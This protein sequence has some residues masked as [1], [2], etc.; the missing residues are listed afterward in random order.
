MSFPK[1]DKSKLRSAIFLDDDIRCR[2]L[3][4]FILFF[5]TT[6]LPPDMKQIQ[7]DNI[8]LQYPYII[9]IIFLHFIAWYFTA[10]FW[11]RY[12]FFYLP[13]IFD[14]YD[15]NTVFLLYTAWR[16]KARFYSQESISSQNA[17]NSSSDMQWFFWTFKSRTSSSELLCCVRIAMCTSVVVLTSAD[18]NCRGRGDVRLDCNCVYGQW[19]SSLLCS[20]DS[21]V[22]Y[23]FFTST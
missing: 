16:L 7:A 23:L 6:I 1:D 18:E 21:A 22:Y 5:S 12:A 9:C 17:Q 3:S 15:N 14:F 13:H 11:V 2:L 19:S 20:L 10:S 4:L 8:V